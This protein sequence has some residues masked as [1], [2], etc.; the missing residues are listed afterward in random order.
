M[1][2]T[3]LKL[4]GNPGKVQ[5][6]VRAFQE[7][8]GTITAEASSGA[9]YVT[10]KVNGKFEVLSVRISEEAMKLNDREVLEDLVAGATNQAVAKVRQQLAE[11]SGKMAAEMGLPPG[12]L[13]GGF[14]GL[15]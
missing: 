1:I 10:V 6:A 9:G 11:E 2:G 12:L 13:V 4:M 5:E 3:L 15:G 7:K 8:V 14:P